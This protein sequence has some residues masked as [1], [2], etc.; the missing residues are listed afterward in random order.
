MT[1]PNM[2]SSTRA[3]MGFFF[4]SPECGCCIVRLPCDMTLP[5]ATLLQHIHHH[6]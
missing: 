2:L 4:D 5:K 3:A 6:V 1:T